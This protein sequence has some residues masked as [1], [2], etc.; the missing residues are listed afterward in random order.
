LDG[1]E[2]D[3]TNS[4]GSAIN[5]PIEEILDASSL[6]GWEGE[7]WLAPSLGRLV[8]L[9]VIVLGLLSGFGAVRTAWGFMEHIWGGGR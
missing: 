4:T 7:G 1:I 2:M 3:M 8:V 9:G 5:E 6:E